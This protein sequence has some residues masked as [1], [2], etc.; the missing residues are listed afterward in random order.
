MS[1]TNDE[2]RSLAQNQLEPAIYVPARRLSIHIS[3]LLVGT[4]V[5]PNQVTLGWGTC[6]VA[7]SGL[8]FAGYQRMAAVLIAV[9]YVLD[10]VDGELAR[11]RGSGSN[12][13][14]ILEQMVHWFTNL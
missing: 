13:G 11:L 3:S 2:L 5:T 1:K 9:A 12:V 6:L 8:F 10:C 7:S 14:S 4:P